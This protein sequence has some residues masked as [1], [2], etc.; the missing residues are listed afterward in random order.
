MS[1]IKWK[2]GGGLVSPYAEISEEVFIGEGVTIKSPEVQI[3]GDVVLVGYTNIDGRVVVSSVG[4]S[5]R[6]Q[7]VVVLDDVVIVGHGTITECHIED[8]ARLYLNGACLKQ[9]WI[10]MRASV[11]GK[12][13]ANNFIIRDDASLSEDAVIRNA[14]LFDETKVYGR[15]VLMGTGEIGGGICL[16][17]DE[18]RIRIHEGHWQRAPK[19]FKGDGEFTLTECVEGR[20][21]AGC[22]CLPVEEWREKA[23]VWG[24][25]YGWKKETVEEYLKGMDSLNL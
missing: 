13:K 6:L 16:T 21:L 17:G 25:R 12:V 20:L 5:L 23:H 22:T 10:S 11:S 14:S 3:S 2:R 15:A 7:D 1:L 8:N 19:V 18:G 4:N 9:G 24:K